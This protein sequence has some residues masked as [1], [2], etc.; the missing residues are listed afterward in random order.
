MRQKNYKRAGYDTIVKSYVPFSHVNGFQTAD[1]GAVSLVN[2]WPQ[3]NN[4]ER[5][6]YAFVT[7]A[8]PGK[9]HNMSKNYCRASKE[10]TG[11][12]KTILV[13]ITRY[14]TEDGNLCLQQQIY[15]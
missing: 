5:L 9:Q 11:Y 1:P 8:F 4:P 7:D 13:S 15:S 12:I 10:V 2:Q 6:T 14:G 3:H